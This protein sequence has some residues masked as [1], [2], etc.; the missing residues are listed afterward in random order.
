MIKH[1]TLRGNELADLFISLKDNRKKSWHT[2]N[3]ILN[4]LKHKTELKGICQNQTA[5]LHQIAKYCFVLGLKRF[6]E[7]KNYHG[8]A[9]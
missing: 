8:C 6:T 3:H 5:C 9:N 2:G 7:K 1:L 4:S